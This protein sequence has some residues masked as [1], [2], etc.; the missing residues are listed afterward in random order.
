[1]L[2]QYSEVW[3]LHFSVAVVSFL[4]L[5]AHTSHFPYPP[6]FPRRDPPSL[7]LPHHNASPNHN[8]STTLKS[9]FLNTTTFSH[10]ISTLYIFISPTASKCQP[11]E[12]RKP[13]PSSNPAPPQICLP[14]PHNHNPRPNPPIKQLTKRERRRYRRSC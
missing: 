10:P 7:H 4:H 2:L 13:S 14:S 3:W 12:P 6:R 9:L 11:K 5:A 1:M 8:Q